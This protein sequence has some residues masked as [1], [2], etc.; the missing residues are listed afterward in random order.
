MEMSVQI[1]SG[2]LLDY[3]LAFTSMMMMM[4]RMEFALGGSRI[5]EHTDC[6]YDYS[7]TIVW[8]GLVFF[9]SRFICIETKS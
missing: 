3:L 8:L 6:D 9:Q 4:M 2:W 7:Y 1:E 5:L